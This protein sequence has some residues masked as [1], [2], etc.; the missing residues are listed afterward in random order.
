M[1]EYRPSTFVYSFLCFLLFFCLFLS[2]FFLYF[3]VLSVAQA[4]VNLFTSSRGMRRLVE[5]GIKPRHLD[6]K[7]LSLPGHNS[8]SAVC[9]RMKTFYDFRLACVTELC[10]Q[11]LFGLLSA[12]YT[13]EAT[14]GDHPSTMQLTRSCAKR[15]WN[16]RRL[17]S[18]R[19]LA[20]VFI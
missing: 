8:P 4:Y 19:Y 2:C 17:D 20:V 3:L 7:F 18:T 1:H 5:P 11:K 9:N 12:A 13:R 14:N 6:G 16:V 15:Q 10:T